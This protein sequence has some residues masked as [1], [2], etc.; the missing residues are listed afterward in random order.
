M[1]NKKALI[2]FLFIFSIS[3]GT[4]LAKDQITK[5]FAQEQNEITLTEDNS[6]NLTFENDKYIIKD[7]KSRNLT[8]QY[9]SM[10]ID[11]R[12]DDKFKKVKVNIDGEEKIFSSESINKYE[13]IKI[14]EQLNNKIEKSNKIEFNFLDENN[15]NIKLNSEPILIFGEEFED[16]A[17]NGSELYCGNRVF[18]ISTSLIEGGVDGV[19]DGMVS[20]YEP[21]TL[22]TDIFQQSFEDEEKTGETKTFCHKWTYKQKMD[23]MA[24]LEGAGGESLGNTHASLSSLLW[25]DVTLGR[26]SKNYNSNIGVFTTNEVYD[27][28]FMFHLRGK[29]SMPDFCAMNTEAKVFSHDKNKTNYAYSNTLGCNPD[30]GGGGGGGGGDLVTLDNVLIAKFADDSLGNS[31]GYANPGEQIKYT[32]NVLNNSSEE[33]KLQVKDPLTGLENF[34]SFS[35]SDNISVNGSNSYT[36]GNLKNGIDLTIPAQSNTQILFNLTTREGISADQ[37]IS[38]KVTITAGEESKYALATIYTREEGSSGKGILIDK[39]VTDSNI[40]GVIDLGEQIKYEI[41]VL[42]TNSSDETVKISDPLTNFGTYYDFSTTDYINFNGNTSTY[43]IADLM[44]GITANVPGGEQLDISFSLTAKSTLPEVQLVSNTAKVETSDQ[45]VNEDSAN[46]YT[47]GDGGGGT[48][49]FTLEKSVSDV[50]GNFPAKPGDTLQ[51]T[52]AF[53][54]PTGNSIDFFDVLEVNLDPETISLVKL[55]DGQGNEVNVGEYKFELINNAIEFTFEDPVALENYELKF[56]VNIFSELKNPEATVISNTVKNADNSL[57]DTAIIPL[58]TKPAQLLTLVSTDENSNGFVQPGEEITYTMEYQ[59][60]EA[61]DEVTIINNLEDP[62]LNKATINNIRVKEDATT[63]DSNRYSVTPDPV[64]GGSITINNILAQTDYVVQFEVNAINNVVSDNLLINGTASTIEHELTAIDV[65]ETSTEIINDRAELAKKVEEAGI[66]DNGDGIANQGEFLKYTIN[67]SSNRNRIVEIS[68]VI[69]DPNL[70]A[71]TIRNLEATIDG[72][73]ANLDVLQVSGSGITAEYIDYVKGEQLEITFEIKVKDTLTNATQIENTVVETGNQPDNSASCTIPLEELNLDET[74]AKDLASGQ[75]SRVS[76]GDNVSYELKIIDLKKDTNDIRFIDNLENKNLTYVKVDGV[77]LNDLSISTSDWTNNSS[78]NIDV[79]VNHDFVKGDNITLKF[80]AKVSDLTPDN[81]TIVNYANAEVDGVETNSSAEVITTGDDGVPTESSLFADKLI[82]NETGGIDGQLEAGEY[83]TFQIVVGNI[84]NEEVNNVLIKDDLA[85][86]GLDQVFDWTGNEVVNIKNDTTTVE[87]KTL[88][89]LI[90]GFRYDFAPKEK[91]YIEFKLQAKQALGMIDLNGDNDADTKISN[92]ALVQEENQNP[93][94][95]GVEIKLPPMNSNISFKKNVI[96]NDNSVPIS[97]YEDVTY[98]LTTINDSDTKATN[99][100]VSDDFEAQKFDKMFFMDQIDT[101]PVVMGAGSSGA[102]I[103]SSPT[104]SDLQ[105]QGIEINVNPHSKVV[106]EFVLTTNTN[107]V[108]IE[109]D[110]NVDL[111]FANTANLEDKTNGDIMSGT[112]EIPMTPPGFIQV[113]TEVSPSMII[114]PGQTITNTIS[115]TVNK[116]INYIKGFSTYNTQFLSKYSNLKMTIVSGG[117]T[118]ILT[119]NDMKVQLMKNNKLD[120][121]NFMV[122]RDFK[123]GDIVTVTY[124]NLSKD[125]NG[126][127]GAGIYMTSKMYHEEEMTQEV[128]RET[129]IA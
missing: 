90:S 65:I 58:E 7:K 122:T 4:F 56:N 86:Q 27:G 41:S 106:L 118:T 71:S 100:F 5:V 35:D 102:I 127:S 9:I 98:Q 63:L 85:S 61:E 124:D 83:V 57:S 82:T 121:L 21:V 54:T 113:E 34:Y 26:L 45:T 46:I 97:K 13:F 69:S 31:D 70:D 12:D 87:Q 51:Y 38:N 19:K 39:E 40:N 15:K 10:E 77:Y 20:P 119:E 28:T 126:Y 107:V 43:T 109:G 76:P 72:N 79:Q 33:V 49:D 52:I 123:K 53:S 37:A 108:D 78:S 60:Q 125:T 23:N 62:L 17:K 3:I 47:A 110:G 30:S 73:P 120:I 67:F 2:I 48:G 116:D 94:Y 115:A 93:L 8:E 74:F 64:G 16:V 81:T 44:N 99:L 95:P 92:V 101:E 105:G 55:Y 129:Q 104:V 103:T 80:T 59:S 68:D 14:T 96:R 111:R 88:N 114:M 42:N 112:A 1:I 75:S 50:N 25:T 29:G 24:Y 22:R 32:I 128:L 117:Q 18:D 66:N 91:I 84:T 11:A 36:I 89:E 6:K